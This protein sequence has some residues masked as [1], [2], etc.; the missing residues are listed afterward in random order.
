MNLELQHWFLLA[1]VGQ[2]GVLI[3]SSLVPQR[4][5]W[6]RSLAELPELHR[7]LF[8]VYGGYTVMSIIAL[9]VICLTCSDE[10]ATGSRLAKAFCTFGAI[11]WGV[12]LSLQTILNAR[13][14]LT[15]WWLAAGYHL[16]TCLFVSFTAVYLAGIFLG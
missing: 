2:L 6:R 14:F 7:Q 15:R 13:P 1:G 16:L 9:G 10:L 3:A 11:F 5:E 8:W 4:L 12:R